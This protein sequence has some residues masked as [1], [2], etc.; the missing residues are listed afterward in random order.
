MR[1][2]MHNVS[3]HGKICYI[4]LPCSDLAQSAAF[5][6]AVFGWSMRT[7]GDG[8]A[9]FDDA[10]GQVSGSFAMNRQAALDPGFLIYIMV[11]DIRHT[12]TAIEAFDCKIVRPL[13]F[14]PTELI[15]HFHDPAGNLLGLYQEPAH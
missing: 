10:N 8:A 4:E 15:A 6:T 9:A 1:E 11:D 3:K 7:R 2:S 14:H 13:G 12:I 5:Y